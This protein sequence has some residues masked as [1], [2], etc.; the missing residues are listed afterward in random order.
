M[1]LTEPN[2]LSRAY[3]ASELARHIQHAVDTDSH[4]G[5]EPY[6]QAADHIIKDAVS[7]SLPLVGTLD[8]P[9]RLSRLQLVAALAQKM[10]ANQVHPSREGS[11]EYGKG[12]ADIALN[13]LA[14]D[15]N[16]P[17]PVN[18]ILRAHRLEHING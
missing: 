9:L 5:S 16:Q 11:L 18:E 12:V 1:S 2:T 14:H 7:L 8:K 6:L 10:E 4:P 3:L 13:L 15:T 17:G